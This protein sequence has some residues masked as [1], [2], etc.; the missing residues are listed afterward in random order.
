MRKELTKD[1]EKLISK[2]TSLT[3]LKLQMSNDKLTDN[4]KDSN[5]FKDMTKEM[6]SDLIKDLEKL[7]YKNNTQ[8]ELKLKIFY[9]TIKQT[10]NKIEDN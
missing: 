6:K 1:M 10:Q 5:I 2:N 7:I 3:E 4:R 9:E 8:S